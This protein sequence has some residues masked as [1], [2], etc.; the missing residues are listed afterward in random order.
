MNKT[1]RYKDSDA[2]LYQ[3]HEMNNCKSL[4]YFLNQI[5]ILQEKVEFKNNVAD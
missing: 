2:L 3:K 1:Q 5:I 4:V